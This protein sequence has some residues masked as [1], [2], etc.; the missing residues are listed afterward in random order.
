MYGKLFIHL[1]RWDPNHDCN[2]DGHFARIGVVLWISGESPSHDDALFDSVSRELRKFGT[3]RHARYGTLTHQHPRR[4]GGRFA[5]VHI[6]TGVYGVTEWKRWKPNGRDLPWVVETADIWR[7]HFGQLLMGLQTG[8]DEAGTYQSRESRAVQSDGHA[9]SGAMPVSA[10]GLSGK[11]RCSVCDRPGLAEGRSRHLK[12]EDSYLT[13]DP[14]VHTVPASA[15]VASDARAIA[16]SRAIAQYR[17]LVKSVERR[18]AATYGRR[19]EQENRRPVRLADARKAV[20][21]RCQGRCENPTCGGQPTD[22]TDDGQPILEVDHI[23]EITAGGRDH[24]VQMVAL[25]PNCHAM[26]GRGLNRE[27]LRAA[28]LNMASRAHAEWDLGLRSTDASKR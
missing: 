23:V 14:L 20:L 10:T 16:K 5:S 13:Q 17:E 22:V 4:E 7:S 8:A 1:G 3:R 9:R 27:A 25:C 2:K 21:L 26:K 11:R 28:L 18:E 6:E 12:C 19:T 24:P 15:A